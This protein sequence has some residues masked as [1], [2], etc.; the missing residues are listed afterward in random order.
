MTDDIRPNSF[1]ALPSYRK[2]LFLFGLLLCTVAILFLIAEI[3]V[4][5]R[6]YFKYGTFTGFQAI[7]EYNKDIGLQTPKPGLKIAGIEINSHGFRSPELSNKNPGTLRLGFLGGSTT[8]SA[9]VTANNLT[10][11]AVVTSKLAEMYPDNNFE[12]INAGV[13]GYTTSDSSANL[14]TRLAIHD[15]DILFIYHGINDIIFDAYYDGVKQGVIPIS[16]NEKK[17]KNNFLLK[18]S[19]LAELAYVNALILLRQNDTDD[20]TVRI[21]LNE[22]L[23]SDRFRYRLQTLVDDALNNSKLVVLPTFTNRLRDGLTPDELSD[24]M[25]THNY[26]VPYYSTEDLLK[27]LNIYNDVIR[28]F[29]EQE[30][31]LVIDSAEAI[32]GTRANFADSVHFTNEGS[33]LFGKYIAARLI[34]SQQLQ[35]LISRDYGISLNDQEI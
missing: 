19:L 22:Q 29:S 17:I 16:Y 34:E 26:Y 9:E 35:N 20:K 28:D 7:T 10:W 25:L 11:P 2:V 8:F 1:E 24:A 32:A 6:L 30:G 23:V 14:K 31:V 13:S 27:A 3:F 21:P 33:E 5:A 18:H 15:N 4:R 12:Y